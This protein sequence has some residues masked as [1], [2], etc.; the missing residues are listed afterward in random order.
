MQKQH[1]FTLDD[2]RIIFTSHT[3]MP[4][5]SKT[6]FFKVFFFLLS[7]TIANRHR[8]SHNKTNSKAKDKIF[9]KLYMYTECT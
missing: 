6:V 9:D 1:M 7:T 4:K 3:E 5:H 2:H 8:L